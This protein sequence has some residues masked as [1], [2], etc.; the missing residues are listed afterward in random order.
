MVESSNLSVHSLQLLCTQAIRNCQVSVLCCGFF[1]LINVSFQLFMQFILVILKYLWFKLYIPTV[2]ELSW[3]SDYGHFSFENSSAVPH[4]DYLW[5]S[6]CPAEL[7]CAGYGAACLRQD[8]GMVTRTAEAVRAARNEAVR[9]DYCCQRHGSASVSALF[10]LLSCSLLLNLS[11]FL[12]L[13]FFVPSCGRWC[14]AL[15]CKGSSWP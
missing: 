12:F 6:V 9:L 5:A 13:S 3:T 1:F 2:L 7:G 11:A 14:W 8:V 10:T 4:W 15:P